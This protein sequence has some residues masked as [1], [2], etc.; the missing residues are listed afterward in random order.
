[1]NKLERARLELEKTKVSAALAEMEYRVMERE[2]DIERL[3]QNIQNQLN[4]IKEIDAK[5]EE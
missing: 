5:L 2:A 4:R 1:M 3:K